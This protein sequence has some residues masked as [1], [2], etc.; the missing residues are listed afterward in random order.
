MIYSGFGPTGVYDVVTA[1]EHGE[2]MVFAAELADAGYGDE[3]GFKDQPV[4]EPEQA[5]D[6]LWAGMLEHERPIAMIAGDAGRHWG[7]VTDVARLLID[8][9]TGKQMKFPDGS[10]WMGVIIE[11][12]PRSIRPRQVRSF[13]HELGGES[14]RLVVSL[15][16]GGDTSMAER[17]ITTLYPPHP[18]TN[19]PTEVVLSIVCP[20]CEQM[21]GAR[22]VKPDG[23]FTFRQH[24]SRIATCG[25]EPP[26]A[27]PV[28]Q[29][30]VS[31]FDGEVD[32]AGVMRPYRLLERRE[33]ARGRAVLVLDRRRRLF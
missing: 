23:T 18:P 26:L 21:V 5:A 16:A 29:L 30:I 10:E 31:F 9:T 8:R 14:E 6:R 22:C 4:L 27:L 17:W 33:P 13:V 3:N 25:Y 28:P 24:Q 11:V 7:H 20:Q 12:D 15:W 2:S 19:P 32:R 1:D